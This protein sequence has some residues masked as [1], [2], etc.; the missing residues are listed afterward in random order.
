MSW[1][2]V[3]TPPARRDL[4]RLDNTIQHRVIQALRR[5]TD[6]GQSDVVKLQGRQDE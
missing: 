6:T 2:Y 1:T 3:I 5:Y 4:R